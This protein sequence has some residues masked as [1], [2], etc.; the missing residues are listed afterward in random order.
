M[1]AAR[2]SETIVLYSNTTRFH[3]S[4]DWDRVLTVIRLEALSIP[5]P[6]H[7]WWCR[8]SQSIN[9]D[10]STTEAIQDGTKCSVIIERKVEKIWEGSRFSKF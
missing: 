4:E 3:I 7:F 6:L 1:D 8:D 10:M 5:E 9:D 2:S